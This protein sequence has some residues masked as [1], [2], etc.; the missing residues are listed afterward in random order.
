MVDLNDN[1]PTL[2][3]IKNIIKNFPCNKASDSDEIQ[4]KLLKNVLKSHT[5]L[6]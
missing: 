4:N 1:L 2:A 6:E 5:T 3:D